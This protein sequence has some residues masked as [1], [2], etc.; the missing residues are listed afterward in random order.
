MLE[1][2]SCKKKSRRFNELK[3]KK[4]IKAADIPKIKQFKVRYPSDIDWK[5]KYSQAIEFYNNEQFD[6][7]FKLLIIFAGQ[8]NIRDKI[9]L[10]AKTTIVELLQE[11]KISKKGIRWLKD[12]ANRDHFMAQSYY[13]WIHYHGIYVKK[14]MKKAFNLFV[15]SAGVPNTKDLGYDNAQYFVGFMYFNGIGVK[16]D[17]HK[18]MRWFRYSSEQNNIRGLHHLG[19]L[20]CGRNLEAAIEWF[21]REA[22]AKVLQEVDDP[23]LFDALESLLL[24][25]TKYTLREY[26]IIRE[27]LEV[28]QL[29]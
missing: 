8:Y 15:K 26:L 5:E 14:N 27:T 11:K 17:I 21:Y 23:N 1:L 28:E 22:R 19:L 12:L 18:A 6:I 10:D 2:F 16:R 3:D 20:C 7:C 4:E 29:K 13:A 24:K 25:C 9:Y